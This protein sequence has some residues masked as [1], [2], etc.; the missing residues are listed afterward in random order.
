MK[1]GAKYMK[2][3]R[4]DPE[5]RKRPSS[6]VFLAA[7]LIGFFLL[8]GF[9]AVAQ[10]KSEPPES[11][12]SFFAETF[13]LEATLKK[14]NDELT[15]NPGSIQVLESKATLLGSHGLIKEAMVVLD[16]I[17]TLLPPEPPAKLDKP[18]KPRIQY[19]SES[20]SVLF[21]IG[22]L[23]LKLGKKEEAKMALKRSL[24]TNPGHMMANTLLG[25]IYLDEGNSEGALKVFQQ[26]GDLSACGKISKGNAL[27]NLQRYAEA[28]EVY[29]VARHW[30]PD[31]PSV[32]VNL[33]DTYLRSKQ[34]EKALA[35][36]RDYFQKAAVKGVPTAEV[37]I[38]RRRVEKLCTLMKI[39][40]DQFLS[41]EPEP[42]TA[43]AP[44]H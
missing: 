31:L 3:E 4:V 36:Y 15:R 17:L 32:H 27:Y 44:S 8:V 9:E 1:S 14:L 34:G 40:P 39:D 5:R 42:R 24:I 2:H 7:C 22:K 33:A 26:G 16:Q 41:P 10:K 25:N 6:F 20:A 28:I 29:E 18:G 38:V 43:S 35:C 19:L 30:R 21:D 23:Y 11:M 37:A 13:P 12:D